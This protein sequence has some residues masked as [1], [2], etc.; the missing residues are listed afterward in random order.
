MWVKEIA[1]IKKKHKQ[2]DILGLNVDY[3][4]KHYKTYFPD[5]TD[6]AYKYIKN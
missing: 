2:L 6:F 4:Q 1:R 3:Y 5:S